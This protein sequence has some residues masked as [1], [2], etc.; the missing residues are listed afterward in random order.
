M[1]LIARSIAV[2]AFLVSSSFAQIGAISDIQN[3][4]L[5]VR[6][7]D[8]G[9]IAVARR[10]SLGGALTA[11]TGSEALTASGWTFLGPYGGDVEDIA[12][13]PTVPSIV[14]AGIAASAG[15]GT[16]YRSTNGGATWTAL[17]QFNG[18]GVY[19]VEFALNG[20]VFLGTTESIWKSTDGGMT[21][22]QLVLGIGLNDVVLAV[23][24]DPANPSTIWIGVDDALGN[25]SQNVLVSMNGGASWTNRT[26]PLS[27]P[28]SCRSIAL[29]PGNSNKV[30]AAFGGAFGGGA[31]WVSTNGGTSWINRSPGL[32]SNPMNSITHDGVRLLVGGGQAFGGQFVGVYSSVNDGASW[33]QVHNASWPNLAIKDIAVDA[34]SPSTLYVASAGSGIFRSVNGGATWSFGVGGTG[35]LS[36][37][38]V[39]PPKTGGTPVYAGNAAAGAWKSLNGIAFGP[40]STGMTYLNLESTAAN[41]LN[42]NELAVAFTGLNNGGVFTSLDGGATW[43]LEPLP[44]T[45]YKF[46]TFAPDG[47][48]YTISDG[49]STIALEGV[50]RRDGGTWTSLGPYQGSLFESEL[51]CIAFD[52][53]NPARLVAAGKDYGVAG[54]EPTVWVFNPAS[55][56]WTKAYEGTIQGDGVHSVAFL[57]DGG[58]QNLVASFAGQTCGALRSLNGGITWNPS[59]AGLGGVA[60]TNSLA[61]SPINSNTVYLGNHLYYGGVGTIYRSTDGGQSWVPRGAPVNAVGLVLDPLRVERLFIASMAGAGVQISENGGQTATPFDTGLTGAG[62]PRGLALVPGACNRLLLATAN[63]A[64]TE[65]GAGCRLETSVASVSLSAG[66]TIGFNIAAGPAQAG[67]LY[68]V[69]GSASGSS[70]GTPVQSILLPLNFDN[71]T[72]LTIQEANTG[73]FVNTLGTLSSTGGANASIIVPPLSNPSLA[74]LSL[75][76]AYASFTLAPFAAYLAS[77]P[78]GVVLVP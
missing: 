72:T 69:G 2:V 71:V 49:P 38:A 68:L 8:Q 44:P 22:T 31:V 1:K 50:Y 59:S 25:Q 57:F 76:F 40:S 70:P 27:A 41:P 64:Y 7:D 63:G 3:P 4:E 15:G 16:A 66:G 52:P 67:L 28:Q 6:R 35:L 53:L 37:N 73:I 54:N 43:A 23:A 78:A 24:L 77:N 42:G 20:D 60:Q 30:Y 32:P 45:R 9:H 46:V 58:N 18:F 11:P 55:S 47:K 34:A 61:A 12:A 39:S 14:I 13:S 65:A 36:V 75:T 29:A 48:L 62:W 26:P 10:P 51:F 19:D 74:G 21:W 33:S 56:T 17:S 5:E